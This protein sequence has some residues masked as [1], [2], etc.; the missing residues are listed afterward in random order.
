[1]ANAEVGD[2]VAPIQS[3]QREGKGSSTGQY[4]TED[5]ALHMQTLPTPVN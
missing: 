2:E 4:P 3:F 1:M 5:M